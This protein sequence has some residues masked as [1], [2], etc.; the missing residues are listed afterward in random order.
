[1][2]LNNNK[3]HGAYKT[4]NLH[5][6]KIT[7]LFYKK[8]KNTLL[9]IILTIFLLISLFTVIQPSYAA[10]T[11][12]N[13][14]TLTTSMTNDTSDWIEIAQDGGYSLILRKEVLPNS[15]TAFSSNSVDFYDSRTPPLA[16]V[17]VNDWFKNTLSSTARLRDFTVKNNAVSTRGSFAALSSGFSVPSSEVARTGDDVAFLLS[18]AEAALFCSQQY[19]TSSTTWIS[20][21]SVAQSNYAKLTLPPGSDED[22]WWLR[23][24]G[25]TNTVTSSVGSHSLFVSGTVYAVTTS[26]AHPYIRPAL[27]V[28]SSI[29]STD[30]YSVIYDVNSGVVGSGPVT[31]TGLL[32][33]LHSLDSVTVPT[34]ADGV[35]DVAVVFVGWSLTQ[36]S[37]IFEKGQSVSLP[38]L[39]TEVMISGADVTVFAVWGYD[40]NGDG[41]P[42]VLEDQYSVTYDGNGHTCGAVPTDNN[43]PYLNGSQV[44]V[45]VQGTLSRRGYTFLGWAT[46]PNDNTP[47]YTAGSTFIITANTVLYAVWRQTTTSSYYTV[48]YQPGTHGTFTI[49]TTRNL[50]YGDSTPVAPKVTGEPGWK[51]VGWS[52]VPSITVTGNAVYVAQWIQEQTYLLTVQFVDWDGTLIK[53]QTVPYGGDASAPNDP[54]REGYTFTGWDCDYTNVTSNL[55]VTAQYTVVSQPPVAIQSWAVLNLVL[56]IVG[57]ILVIVLTAWVLLQRKQQQRNSQS[58]SEVSEKQKSQHRNLWLAVVFAMG[59]TGVVVFLLTEDLSCTMGLVDS[60]TIVN[61]I[62]LGVEVVVATFVFKYKKCS[63]H[64]ENSTATAT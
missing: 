57:L 55:T 4:M 45:L 9:S 58:N 21:S 19:A 62:V 60:W 20:S 37:M 64:R 17:S 16:R 36:T 46:S 44:T 29:F 63:S 56:S 28:K 35:G 30:L 26:V 33:G 50:V 54:A 7:P 61:A 39:V 53:S 12:V 18:F 42:D 52:P 51:F 43:S 14:R 27:W 31:E 47:I 23:S 32:S 1:L 40:R 41:D 22:F 8:E 13:G 2:K 59:I 10:S 3:I 15:K 34:H 38:V 24:P 49:Q 11:A 6:N 5:I 25:W 48:T